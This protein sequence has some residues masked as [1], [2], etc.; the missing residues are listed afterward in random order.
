MA[1]KC[2]KTDVIFLNNLPDSKALVDEPPKRLHITKAAETPDNIRRAAQLEPLVRDKR[3]ADVGAGVGG[4]LLR[5]HKITEETV[6][7]DIDT[8]VSKNYPCPYVNHVLY[9]EDEHYDVITMYHSLEHIFAFDDILQV[10]WRKLKPEG[11][12]IIEVP[13]A[14]DYILNSCEE[15]RKELIWT[16]HLVLHT[17]ESLKGL[18]KAT[19]FEVPHFQ[20]LQRYPISNHLYWQ[21]H[22]KSDGHKEWSHIDGTM[23]TQSY[24][25]ALEKL[26]M[27]DT[28]MAYATKPKTA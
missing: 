21:L 24:R 27:T 23:L 15:A 7:V 11:K 18:L 20:Y 22:G 19:G 4:L 9:L 1:L 17:E 26:K 12:L 13:H 25:I 3:W 8:K 14:R 10:I 6:G 16:E 28:V 2:K 5:V